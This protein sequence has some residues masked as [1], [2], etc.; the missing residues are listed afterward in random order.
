MK[1]KSEVIDSPHKLK[2]HEFDLTDAK[3]AHKCNDIAK[4]IVECIGGVCGREMKTLVI[5]G[6]KISHIEPS[7]PS[8]DESNDEKK[9]I[10]NEECDLH[11]K[12]QD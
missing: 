8:G 12:K 1:V 9:A 2:S 5:S 6:I 10:W 4:K 7:C 11:M 3:E